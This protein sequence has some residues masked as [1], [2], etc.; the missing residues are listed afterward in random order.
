MSRFDLA[1]PVVLAHEGGWA[2]HPADPGGA[3]KY[4][5]SLRFLR[6]QGLDM[7]GDGDVDADDVRGLTP[8]QAADLYRERF[9]DAYRYD[10]IVDSQVAGKVLDVAVNLGPKRA[11]RLVQRALR[12]CGER[13]EVDGVFGPKTVSAVNDC[14]AREL[15]IELCHQ[16]ATYY[17]TLVELHPRFAAFAAGWKRRAE[18]PFGAGEYVKEPA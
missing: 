18:W 9:W 16:Q 3:T 15:L 11:H 10:R 12:E 8:T 2:N 17:A 6:A 13:V 1:I 4:G 7:D 14:E 5:I